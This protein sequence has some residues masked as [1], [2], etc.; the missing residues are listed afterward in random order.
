MV[1][2]HIKLFYFFRGKREH[3]HFFVWLQRE[4]PVGGGW[5][6]YT[7]FF[8]TFKD[9]TNMRIAMGKHRVLSMWSAGKIILKNVEP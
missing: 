4:Y 5:C 8:C 2:D 9:A 6:N 7:E 3:L 1:P